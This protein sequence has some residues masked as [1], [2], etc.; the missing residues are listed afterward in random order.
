MERKSRP[1]RPFRGAGFYNDIEK[2]R[3]EGKHGQAITDSSYWSQLS[4]TGPECVCPLEGNEQGDRKA[5]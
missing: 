1:F 5:G 3:R 4:Q 2:L